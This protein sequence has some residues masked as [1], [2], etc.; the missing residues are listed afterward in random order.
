VTASDG[1]NFDQVYKRR[2]VVP[3]EPLVDH[4]E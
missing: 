2:V 1:L 4:A 3:A